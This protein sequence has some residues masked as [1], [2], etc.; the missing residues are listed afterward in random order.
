MARD[1][2]NKIK[3]KCYLIFEGEGKEVSEMMLN[4][5]KRI[6]REIYALRY[7]GTKSLLQGWAYENMDLTRKFKNIRLLAVGKVYHIPLNDDNKNRK[8]YY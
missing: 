7:N 2:D 6:K 8:N 1:L 5:V 3:L 4:H